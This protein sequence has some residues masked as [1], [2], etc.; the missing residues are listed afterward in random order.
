MER[1]ICMLDDRLR[2][3]MAMQRE[4]MH[5][6]REMNDTL[7]KV[8]TRLVDG[9]TSFAASTAHPMTRPA[10][11]GAKRPGSPSVEPEPSKFRATDVRGEP[12]R[13]RSESDSG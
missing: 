7:T 10:A 8:L 9:A 5:L 1:L 13:A 2:Q 11:R 4:Q 12:A 3:Q 6:Q